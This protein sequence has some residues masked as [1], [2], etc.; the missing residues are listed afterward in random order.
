MAPEPLRVLY[1]AGWG[2]S[3]ST[4]LDRML[5]QVPGFFSVGEAREL[6]QRG[7]VENRLCGCGAAFRECPFWNQVGDQGFGGW[8]RVDAHQMV[9][10][11]SALDRPWTVPFLIRPGI[12]PAM[13]ADLQ[14]Y[15]GNLDKLYRA[16]ASASGA[17]TIIDSSKIPSYA[18]VLRRMPATDIRAVHLVRDSRGVVF[19]WR[20][21]VVRPDS[22]S[23]ADYMGRYDVASASAR[24]VAYNGLTQAL[25][26]V[27]I[28]YLLL[29]YEDVI[30]A[31]RPSLERI[32][33]FAGSQIAGDALSFLHNGSVNLGTNH[34]VDGNPMRFESGSVTLRVD[35]QWRQ[36]MARRERLLVSAI[37]APLLLRYGYPVRG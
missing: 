17:R 16:I 26:L 29:R 6:W 3:G 19:S 10:L 33:S 20:K 18:L 12:R 32:L 13:E 8:D 31:P 34:T 22:S 28:P 14:T 1:I 30:A 37:T 5:G 11:R 23:K 21:R 36:G 24:Y 2:R 9:R 7:C 27:G 4:L 15:V 35:Q 25:R